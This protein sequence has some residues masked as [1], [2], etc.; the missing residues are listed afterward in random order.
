MTYEFGGKQYSAQMPLDPDPTILLRVSTV[1]AQSSGQ[2]YTGNVAA[3]QPGY[4][5]P[6]TVIES[7]TVYQPYSVQPTYPP[8][9]LSLD[10]GYWGGHRRR[11]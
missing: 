4:Q 1:G 6:P 8:V 5:Q 9:S 7:S 3:T 10:Y 2:G 11:R